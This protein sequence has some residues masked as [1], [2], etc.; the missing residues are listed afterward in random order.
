MGGDFGARMDDLI[1]QVGEGKLTG[2]VVVDQVYAKYQHERMD[3]R[4][5]RGGQA[6]YLSTPLMAKMRDYFGDLAAEVL[7]G[8]LKTAMIKNVEDL[9]AKQ[10]F[11]HAPREFEDLRESGHPMVNDDGVDVYDRAPLVHRLSAAELRV[12]DR[13]RSQGLGGGGP[14]NP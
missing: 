10:V 7:H 11:D 5:P 13:L 3:L 14:V 8:S 4:H 2:T 1:A 6:R 9:A 12:K